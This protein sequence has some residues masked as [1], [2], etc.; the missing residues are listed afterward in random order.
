VIWTLRDGAF[1]EGAAVPVTDRGFRYGMSLF[2]TVAV[3]EGRSLFWEE[4]L[5]RLHQ[6]GAAA[7][8][9]VPE[10]PSLPELSG[11]SGLLRIYLTAGDGAPSSPVEA[12]RVFVL[13]DEAEFPSPEAVGRGL[14][15]TVSRAPLGSVLGGW[16]TGCYWPHVQ[17]FSEARRQGFDEAVVCNL[18]GAVTSAAMANLFLVQGGRVVTPPL[19][20]GARDGVVREWVRSHI[21]VEETLLVVEDLEAAAECFVTNSRLGVLPVSE[22]D[23]RPLPSRATGEWLA[24]LY[25]EK[26]LRQ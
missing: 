21:P 6:A 24:A 16:K 26:I 15:L 10:I 7:E 19:G 4:H 22:I 1:H 9:P 11:K 5:H 17:A 20:S 3:F 23:G 2:E 12:P 14:R 18:Q 13:F 25:R 8:F